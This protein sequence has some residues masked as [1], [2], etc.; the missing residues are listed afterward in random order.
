VV[1]PGG[2]IVFLTS[3]GTL[4]KH[5][6]TV[7]RRLHEA[8]ELLGAFRLPSGV[9]AATSGSVSGADLLIFRKR[10]VPLT[11]RRDEPAWI[12]T[13]P[14]DYRRVAGGQQLT[15]GSR[16]T[17]P[18][19]DPDRRAAQR[20]QVNAHWLDHSEAVIGTP[21]VVDQDDSLWLQ[22]Q[23]PASGIAAALDAALR[24][25]LPDR[26]FG[27]P[28][29]AAEVAPASPLRATP[30]QSLDAAI[31]A[32]DARHRPQMEALATIYATAKQ[33]LAAELADGDGGTIADLRADLNRHYDHFVARWGA[34][35]H[36]RI[37]AR[38]RQV[39]ELRFLQALETDPQPVTADRWRARK[40]AIFHTCTVRPQQ[41]VLPGTLT[42]DEAL[43]W[44]LDERGAADLGRIAY[45][46]GSTPDAVETALGDR[47]FRD[48]HTG[49]WTTADAYLS[50]DVRVKLDQAERAAVHDARYT[51]NVAALTAVQPAPLGPAEII[52]TPAAVWL[53]DDVATAFVQHLL[54]AFTGT[55]RFNHALGAWALDDRDQRGATSVEAFSKWGTARTNAIAILDATFANTPIMVYDE[56]MVKGSKRRVFNATETVAAQDKQAAIRTAFTEWLW[57]DAAR[58]ERLCQIYNTRFNSVVL[59]RYDGSHLQLPG[60]NTALLRAGDL[61]PYQKAGVWQM[62]QNP[63]TL[64]AFDT[65]GGKTWTAC[66]G[67]MESIRLGL[68]SK[69]LIVVPNNLVGQWADALQALYPA[70]TILPL[71]PEEFDPH[72][73]GVALSRIATGTWQAVIIGQTSLKALP[74]DAGTI[75]T[76]RD[77][78]T[79]QLR[80]YLEELRY[81][82]TT[83]KEKRSFKQIETAVDRFEARLDGLE[84]GIRRDSTRTI[85]WD[86][87]GIDMIVVDECQDFKNLWTMTR[88]NVP[89]VPRAGSQRALDLRIKTWELLRRRA[90][91]VFLTATPV[92]NTI[93]EVYIMQ[94]YLQQEVLQS[95]GIHHFDAWVSLFGEIA[96]AFEM[97]PDGS[98]FRMVRR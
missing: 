79:D 9:F 42:V 61:D 83:S 59:R 31:A 8:A 62:V 24:C 73:R 6:A 13:A 28:D 54:P 68:A 95:A 19:R 65:G 50:G 55:V 15:H 69:A 91:V 45:L 5:S 81:T 78:E 93:G 32:L 17:S 44:C 92:M 11:P 94:R 49:R 57:T 63:A 29:A 70:A 22:I 14:A 16:Y 39:P 27:D 26:L 84:Q 36:P 85:T 51:R 74:I 21:R 35:S 41:A 77:E 48:P 12:M 72:R 43:A 1:R 34:L 71:P 89:G 7:R 18:E 60:M 64:L 76:F 47:V 23:A 25:N 33:L 37:T 46:S 10:L 20:L 98:G 66:A 2:L 30:P 88:L 86:E 96:A 82:A 90:K 38:L 3:W 67:M 4:D 40:A 97:K 80:T 52:V 75:R 56:I 87:L 58:T 53:P